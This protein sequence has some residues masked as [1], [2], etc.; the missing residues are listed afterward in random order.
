MIVEKYF[1]QLDL[2]LY[3]SFINQYWIN[4]LSFLIFNLNINKLLLIPSFNIV[5]NILHVVKPYI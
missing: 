3:L 4:I 5:Q 2:A 1:Y